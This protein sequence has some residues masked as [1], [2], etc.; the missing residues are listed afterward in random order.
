[1][2]V[3]VGGS[4]RGGSVET[5]SVASDPKPAA[6]ASGFGKPHPDNKTP[7]KTRRLTT[8]ARPNSVFNN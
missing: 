6:P 1:M 7:P 2:G 4:K 5:V 8:I 3:A